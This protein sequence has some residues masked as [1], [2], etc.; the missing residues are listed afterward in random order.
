MTTQKIDFLQKVPIFDGLAP[1]EL[2]AIAGACSE[3][4]YK[5]G[6]MIIQ[7]GEPGDSMFLIV[8]GQVKVF[9]CENGREL[10]LNNMNVGEYFGE[11][12]CL[13]GENRSASITAF[14]TTDVLIIEKDTLW[15]LMRANSAIMERLIVNLVERVRD[16]T[17]SAKNFALTGVYRRFRA[18]MYD[19]ARASDGELVIEPAL[20][21]QEIANRVG[22]S[23][24][25]VTRIMREMKRGGYVQADHKR[26]VIIKPWPRDF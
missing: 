1:N 22:S 4:S 9:V 5:R 6:E 18:L 3:R 17:E 19:M 10:V 16:L 26:A 11:L 8:R 20:T 2:A 12:A 7:E 24:E 13:D 21:H 14:E 15:A 25:M 23:R